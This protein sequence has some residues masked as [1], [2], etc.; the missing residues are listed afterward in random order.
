MSRARVGRERCP[1]RKGSPRG[2]HGCV[3]VGRRPLGD[4]RDHLRGRGVDDVERLARLRPRAADVVAEDALVPS[5]PRERF[6][7][8]LRRGAVLHRAENLGDARHCWLLAI[9]YWLLA[10]GY[11]LLAIG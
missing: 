6:F 3:D 1:R 9:G 4:A 8:A 2:R 10:I 11:W 7:L 5:E